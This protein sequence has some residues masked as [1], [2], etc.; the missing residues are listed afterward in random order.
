MDNHQC[1]KL[2]D[3]IELQTNQKQ[4][5]EAVKEMRTEMQDIKNIYKMIYEL[6][7]SFNTLNE[8]MIN[9]RK[10]VAVIKNDIDIMKGRPNEREQHFLKVGIGAII[11][12]VVGAI[13][14][15]ILIKG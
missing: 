8:N 13:L 4:N 1:I 3:I 7:S 11:T 6:T 15:V 12:I 5:L 9:T 2:K 14:R 10:D